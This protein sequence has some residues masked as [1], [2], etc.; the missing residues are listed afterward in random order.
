MLGSLAP[1]YKSFF[2]DINER[3]VDLKLPFANSWYV[4]KDFGGSASIKDVLPVLVPELS[5]KDNDISEGKTAQRLWMEAVLDGKHDG[6]K[7]KILKDLEKYCKL[8]TMA[9]VEIYKKLQNLNA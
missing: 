4:H 8:D 1:E 7:D 5:Y 2:E 6:E 9:M 3:I